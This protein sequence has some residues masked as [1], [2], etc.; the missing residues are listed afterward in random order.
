MPIEKTLTVLMAAET[1]ARRIVEEAEREAQE[2]RERTKK[3]AQEI[4]EKAR[5]QEASAFHV[6]MAKNEVQR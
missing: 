6:F 3:E 5:K 1:D 4:I 2:L